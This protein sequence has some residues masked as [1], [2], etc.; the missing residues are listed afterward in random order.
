MIL[1]FSLSGNTVLKNIN[2]ILNTDR[3]NFKLHTS[4][5]I[6]GEQWDEEKKRPKNIYLKKYKKLN[7]KLD[8]LKKELVLHINQRQIKKK[9]IN[10]KSLS[11]V[12]QRIMDGNKE[13]Q[14]EN[15]LLSLIKSYIAERNDF[16]SFS[17][18]KRYKVFYN[19]I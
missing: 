9:E 18:Y 16:I 11:R 1:D 2:L 12:V 13:L 3:V 7:N 17:T 10:Q 5:R 15:S 8:S 6:S 14:L 19:L 4:L